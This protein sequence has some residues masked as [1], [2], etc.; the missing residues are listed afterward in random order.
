MSLWRNDGNGGFERLKYTDPNTPFDVTG[1]S[2]ADYN[3]DGAMDVIFSGEA[4]DD[5]RSNLGYI[6]L[7]GILGRGNWI[8][9]DLEDPWHRRGLGARVKI[10][11]GEMTNYRTQ[12]GGVV[13]RGASDV[14]LHIGLGREERAIVDVIWPDGALSS[15]K[16]VH[17][18]TLRVS[19]PSLVHSD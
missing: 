10:T 14:R 4:N 5:T 19:H 6:L 3:R 11:A 9:L 8:A 2:I 15:V 17:G 16:A 18:E 12:D 1:M 13:R 7:E